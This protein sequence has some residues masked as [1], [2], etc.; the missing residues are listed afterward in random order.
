MCNKTPTI[1][2]DTRTPEEIEDNNKQLNE[3]KHMMSKENYEMFERI[4]NETIADP[5]LSDKEKAEKIRPVLWACLTETDW[6]KEGNIVSRTRKAARMG[7]AF[8]KLSALTGLN[9]MRLTKKEV[10]ECQKDLT[11]MMSKQKR[12]SQAPSGK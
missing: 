10:K 4:F 3:Y 12:N 11:S 7:T 8:T 9:K 1:S 6:L 5:K 2:G